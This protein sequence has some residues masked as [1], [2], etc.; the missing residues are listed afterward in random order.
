[1]LLLVVVT[2]SGARARW[3]LGGGMGLEVTAGE[4][5]RGLEEV[6]PVEGGVGIAVD[7]WDLEGVAGVYGGGAESGMT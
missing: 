3:T 4:E 1:M 7:D 5:G 2:F 6:V